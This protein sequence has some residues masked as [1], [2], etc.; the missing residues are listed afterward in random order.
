[1]SGKRIDIH[2]SKH[3]FL[4]MTG[5][6]MA[7]KARVQHRLQKALA[8]RKDALSKLGDTSSTT[9][10]V[11]EDQQHMVDLIAMK[12]AEAEAH[13]I[14]GKCSF[15][16]G[17][18]CGA[19]LR[20]KAT[21]RMLESY[22]D[23]TTEDNAETMQKLRQKL[24]HDIALCHLQNSTDLSNCVEACTNALQAAGPAADIHIT[25]S[26]AQRQLGSFHEAKKDL[27]DALL[28]APGDNTIV[29]AVRE[30]RQCLYTDV[31]NK[32]IHDFKCKGDELLNQGICTDALCAYELA[33]RLLEEFSH[34]EIEDDVWEARKLRQTLFFNTALSHFKKDAPERLEWVQCVEACTNALEAGM[35]DA[36]VLIIRAQA[37]T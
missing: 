18:F 22:V 15:D 24:F 1:M 25:R 3:P 2:S 6:K 23:K 32:K 13:H 26:Q 31:K 37:C 9:S 33:L 5:S 8:L 14:R 29:K 28:A 35:V 4:N 16:Q 27:D 7:G 10:E 30:E 12:M 17:D 34:Q 36:A 20:F 19:E 11:A 21:I